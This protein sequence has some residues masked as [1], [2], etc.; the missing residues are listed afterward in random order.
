MFRE[1][2]L[3]RE[4]WVEV[5]EELKTGKAAQDGA[6]RVPQDSRLEKPPA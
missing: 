4:M 3:V 6:R 2:K 5:G 1:L